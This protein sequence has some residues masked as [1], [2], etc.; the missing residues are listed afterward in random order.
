MTN[1][2]KEVA[3]QTPRYLSNYLYVE[4]GMHNSIDIFGRR[5]ATISLTLN[6]ERC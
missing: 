3:K 6:K 4:V 1:V 2:D 5:D